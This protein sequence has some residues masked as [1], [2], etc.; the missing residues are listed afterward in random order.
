MTQNRRL[1]L[2]RE[3]LAE[4]STEELAVVNGA[5]DAI[6]TGNAVCQIVNTVT[7]A[8]MT[9]CYTCEA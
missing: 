2:K 5:A 9:Y 4:L 6:T 3:A 7:Y 1:S 8:T